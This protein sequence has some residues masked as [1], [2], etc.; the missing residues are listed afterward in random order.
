MISIKLDRYMRQCPPCWKNFIDDL[1]NRVTPDKDDGFSAE[2]IN[3]ELK[4]FR[5]IYHTSASLEFYDES[6]YTFFM[7]KYGGKQ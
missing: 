6:R 5:A 4:C 1:R 7:I 3:R 2:T